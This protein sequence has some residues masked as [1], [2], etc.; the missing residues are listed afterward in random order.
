M[1]LDIY[2]M[3][4]HL[5]FTGKFLSPIQQLLGAQMGDK[6]KTIRLGGELNDNA[7]TAKAKV[8]ALQET[9][10]SFTKMPIEWKDEGEVVFGE[11]FN[12]FSWHA[13]RAFAA[14]TEYP[15][16]S[17]ILRR[18]QPFVLDATPE[19]HPGVAQIWQGAES[20]FRHLI[21]H[22]DNCGFYFPCDFPK[23]KRLLAQ[24]GVLTGSSIRLLAELNQL[25]GP[26]QMTGDQNASSGNQLQSASDPLK[27][28]KYAWSRLHNAAQLSVDHCLPIVFDG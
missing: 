28:I 21:V 6:I 20:K 19:R 8:R 15:T 13:L 24:T 7:E 16:R 1:S 11:Q 5:Y 4:L 10:A 27:E 18:P 12:Y 26:L 2:V 17:F 9:L 25:Q 3:P 14:H 22:A 23:P